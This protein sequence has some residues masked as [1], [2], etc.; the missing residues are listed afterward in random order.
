MG[1]LPTCK[2]CVHSHHP[3][4]AA[5]LPLSAATQD[6]P[7]GRYEE[8]EEHTCLTLL[9]AWVEDE[10]RT[11]SAFCWIA[12]C[13]RRCHLDV[14]R[15]L[16]RFLPAACCIKRAHCRR[17]NFIRIQCNK[18]HTTSA[19]RSNA[20]AQVSET[21]Y[22]GTEDDVRRFQRGRGDLAEGAHCHVQKR[23]AWAECMQ[24]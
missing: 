12:A 23:Y 24:K 20:T 11:D 19:W 3:L 7:P 4:S 10:Q 6:P 17:K 13:W 8:G 16:A 5:P 18:R 21:R 9:H 22:R 2:P 14:G 1:T 15:L